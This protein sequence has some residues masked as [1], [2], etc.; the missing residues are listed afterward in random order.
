MD[1]FNADYKLYFFN[2]LFS[3]KNIYHKT[4]SAQKE[5]LIFL[6]YNDKSLLNID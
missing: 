4:S 3:I 1:L 5:S 6:S 2:Y